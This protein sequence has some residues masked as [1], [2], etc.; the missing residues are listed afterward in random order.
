MKFSV[1]LGRIN[2]L[3]SAFRAQSVASDSGSKR[4]Q[5]AKAER[6]MNLRVDQPMM[7]AERSES[8]LHAV[9]A[10]ARVFHRHVEPARALR[11]HLH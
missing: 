10:D 5:E 9:H 6:D 1:F 4:T 7:N 11:D 3:A 2:L 8:A